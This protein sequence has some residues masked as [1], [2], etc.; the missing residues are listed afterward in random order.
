MGAG[1]ACGEDGRG[2]R[3]HGDDL[4]IGILGFQILANAGD[5]AAGTYTGYES[6]DRAVG[7][8]PD[9][10]AGSAAMDRRIGGVDKLTGHKA[11]GDLPGQFFR[12]CD[13]ALHTL[14]ALR[15]Y[16]LRAVGLHELAALDGHGLRHNDDDAVAPCGCNGGKADAGVAAGRFDDDRAFLQ[17]APFLGVVDHGLGNAILDRAGRIEVLQL[18]KDSGLKAKALF[19]MGQLQQRRTADELVSRGK[20]SFRHFKSLLFII[21]LRLQSRVPGLR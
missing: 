16:K 7:V 21:I 19:N 17:Q 12:P 10:R 18:G 5:G 2:S 13:G 3:L 6:V 9:L 1:N 15:Q 14:G 11:V 4:D 20:N 8:L